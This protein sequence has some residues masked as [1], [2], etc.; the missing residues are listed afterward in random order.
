MS[1]VVIIVWGDGSGGGAI[2][3][4]LAI[5]G[6]L[7]RGLDFSMMT[8]WFPGV[9][10]STLRT[11]ALRITRPWNPGLGYFRSLRMGEAAIRPRLVPQKFEL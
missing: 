10:C 9:S 7:G 4:A 6:R 11:P 8:A 1:H 5:G 3:G 2:A